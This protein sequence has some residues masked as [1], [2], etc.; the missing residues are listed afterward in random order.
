MDLQVST[1]AQPSGRLDFIDAHR[2]FAVLLMLWMHTADGWLRPEL[3]Q[4]A[5]WDLIRA[6]GG[7]AAP[8]FLLLSGLGLALGWRVITAAA[9]VPVHAAG[10]QRSEVARGLQ[11]I[12][13]GYALRLQ[14]WML[15]AAGYSL[16]EG[17]AA[18][19]PLAAAFAAAYLGLDAW[20]RGLRTARWLGLIAALGACVGY[21][22]V[23]AFIPERFA[24]L[25]RVDVL[26]A[27]GASLVVL[28]A[29]REPLQRRPELSLWLAAAAA[30][31]T[32][33][34][35][36]SMPGPL[37]PALAGYIAQ[38]ETLPGQ[39]LPTLFP[40]FPWISYA[41]VGAWVGLRLGEKQRRD[42]GGARFAVRLAAA[43][44]VLVLVACEPLPTARFLRAHWPWLAPLL[45][46]GYRVGAALLL[47]GLAVLVAHPRTPLRG[48]PI[49]L[50]RA[51]LVIYWVH[52]QFA[53]GSAAK[54]IVRTLDFDGWAV[55][56]GVLTVAMT[57]LASTWVGFR[58]RLRRA[59]RKQAERAV[60][61]ENPSA[62]TRA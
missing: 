44:A 41:L 11:L 60:S 2:G 3:K 17:W 43:A 32:P 56:L 39:P 42:G 51:S 4:G 14:M 20:A 45:R 5:S 49:A 54:P 21:G 1:N 29:V 55:G 50:G 15:D 52:L 24:P 36:A 59:A 46:V 12:V 8:T 33:A 30:L 7:L 34:A 16:A 47:G 6:L 25:L 40:L 48:V 26:Q 23:A 57:V 35:R 28:A 27:I 31:A 58:T 22:L 61:A 18:A 62:L 10:A 13:L 53:F 38:W 9:A 19:V 37:P